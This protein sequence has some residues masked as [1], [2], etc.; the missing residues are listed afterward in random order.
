[1]LQ[2]AVSNVTSERLRAGLDV[3]VD[4]IVGQP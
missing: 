4:R 3:A 1:M 2:G